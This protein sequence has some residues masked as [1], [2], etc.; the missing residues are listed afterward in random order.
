MHPWN[1]APSSDSAEVSAWRLRG[2]LIIAG[3]QAVVFAGLALIVDNVPLMI[4]LMIGVIVAGV[5]I[6]SGSRDLYHASRA[7]APPVKESP[8]GRGRSSRSDAGAGLGLP[9]GDL[10]GSLVDDPAAHRIV[11]R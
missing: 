8:D 10:T 5:Q 1:P 7:A 6:I 11:S 2:R 4:L 3:A 9:F